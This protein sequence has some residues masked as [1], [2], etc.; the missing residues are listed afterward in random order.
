MCK[1][2][3]AGGSLLG[4]LQTRYVSLLRTDGLRASSQLTPGDP[5]VRKV[6]TTGS[7]GIGVVSQDHL[8]YEN[9]DEDIVKWM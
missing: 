5:V 7:P 2:Y 9:G 8:L 6:L 4:M 3:E 1:Y